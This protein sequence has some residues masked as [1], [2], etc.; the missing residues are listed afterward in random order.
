MTESR[1]SLKESAASRSSGISSAEVQYCLRGEMSGL[2]QIFVLRPGENKVGALDSND[3]VLP[4]AGVS[5]IHARLVLMAD[6]SLKI[7]DLSSKNGTFANGQRIGEAT[8]A[9][10][11][12]VRFG[13]VIL[14][15][16]EFHRDDAKL[17]IS[18]DYP[19]RDLQ[20][21]AFQVQEL[22]RKTGTQIGSINR[23]WLILAESFQEQ[24]AAAREEDLAPALAHLAGELHLEAA[25]LLEQPERGEPI[26]LHAVGQIDDDASEAIRRRLLPHLKGGESGMVFDAFDEAGV[27]SLTVVA[28]HGSGHDP[29]VLALR[30]KFPGRHESELFLRLVM[31]M[32]EP[33]RPQHPSEK[34][35]LP[36]EF[37]GLIVPRDYIYGRSESMRRIYELMQTLARGDL[38]VLIIGETGAGKEYLAQILHN[39]SPRRRG[40]FIAINCAAIP[41]D[42]L[43][44]E[45][46]G[47]GDGVA[48]GV[49]ARKGRFQLAHGGTLFL[50][51]IGDM[52]ADLQAKLLRA[53]QEKE[54]H[55][56]GKEPVR[57]DVRVLGATNQDLINRI[58]DGSFRADLYYR[59]AGYVLEI[60]PLRERREDIPPLV[61]HFLRSCAKELNRSIRGL[62]V[63]A[64]QMLV[65]YPWPGN[66]RELANEVRRAVYLCPDH[67]T[68]ES[69]TLSRQI[70]QH[71]PAEPQDGRQTGSGVFS[72][73]G[74]SGAMPGYAHDPGSGSHAAMRD[75]GSFS[76]IRPAPGSLVIDSLN[77]D[78]VE[79]LVLEEALRRCA[80]NQVQAA[81]LL[82]ISRQKL[83][84]KME[85][86]GRLRPAGS[87]GV[88]ALD[89]EEDDD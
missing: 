69:S 83:R 77:L 1:V 60:P 25:L 85:R 13:P 51:E 35:P 4:L 46:F 26:V 3:V 21:A 31:R 38:P 61:E 6:G 54:I 58:Q 50:D 18:V 67:R 32:L 45:L 41:S 73:H 22:P 56:L 48:T 5:R 63:R 82:G 42:L 70:Q 55:P 66:V 68:I 86:L 29:L 24:L 80:E 59:L 79:S 19:P 89:D 81:R 64:L 17:A 11:S 57:V 9:P 37:P 30:G 2:E 78:H 23:Q 49:T 43:E 52:S 16:Q 36:T 33:H 53:L 34:T 12:E 15:Y 71:R 74:Q 62:T 87:R 76:G 65:E 39:S 88:S 28:S 72:A 8:V 7:Q 10:G 47:I 27:G 84:R 44:A 75:S 20:T 40:P 14:K